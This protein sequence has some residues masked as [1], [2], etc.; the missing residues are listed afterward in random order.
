M[1]D[2]RKLY[3]G[4]SILEQRWREPEG[5]PR[6]L[7]IDGHKDRCVSESLLLL[8][9]TALVTPCDLWDVVFG[10]VLIFLISSSVYCLDFDSSRIVTGSRDRTIK[11]W[12]IKTG[13]CMATFEGHS[14]SVLCLKFERDWDLGSEGVSHGFM[15]SGSSDCTVCVW[16]LISTPITP[17]ERS[18]IGDRPGKSKDGHPTAAAGS[19]G[20]PRKITA[21]IR[22]VL[23]GHS[24]GVL[25]LRM[26]ERW[27]V[28][29]SK[30]ALMNV[31]DR[32]TLTLHTV[33]RGHEGPVNAVGL[34]NGRVVSASGDGKMMLWDVETGKCVRVFEGHEKGLACIEFKAR[35]DL[36]LSGSNDCTIK[37]WRASTGECLHTFA[38]HTL[39]VRA[40]CFE[41]KTGYIVSTSYDKSVRVWEWREGPVDDGAQSQA[42]GSSEGSVQ[43]KTKGVGRLVREFRNLHASHIFDVKFDV[44]KIVSTSHDQ[45]IV[46]LDFSYGIE[47]AELFS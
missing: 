16:D 43:R 45:K 21:E 37:L 31:Y 38:G 47:G 29:C 7:R 5:E 19:F 20:P 25:D 2:W 39:L 42:G 24:A 6:V 32:K 12:C 26:D 27:I 46:V 33:L 15:V 4:R 14:G 34:E 18:S 40:L 23:R 11:V 10:S 17:G 3:C 28:T 9:E 22:K 1:L 41:P 36:I 8:Y 30:D 13:R 35:D 44:G